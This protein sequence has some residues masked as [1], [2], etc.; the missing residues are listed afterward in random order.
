M[1]PRGQVTNFL[2]G[3]NVLIWTVFWLL[4]L[5]G[6]APVEG[7]FIPARFGAA[8]SQ[9]TGHDFLVPFL[10]TPLSAAFLHAG[11]FHLLVNMLMLLFTGRF[12]EMAL[13]KKGLILLYLVG[14]YA[15]ALG[16]FLP[17]PQSLT[18]MVGASG[19][20]SAVIAAYM[21]LFSRAAPR[22]FGPISPHVMRMGSL[23]LLWI[24]LNLGIVF[25][26]SGDGMR[27][28][29]GAHIG[30]FAAGLLMVRP[31]LAWRHRN[32]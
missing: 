27:I 21:M 10:L 29:I 13:G 26:L 14:A 30:G 22:R 28:A 9:I 25:A 24:I 17:H 15:A 5:D 6:V 12:V 19:P 7:G 23:M 4:G 11:F 18:P 20:G 1:I 31:L 32:A 8:L 16:E 2:V 3:L